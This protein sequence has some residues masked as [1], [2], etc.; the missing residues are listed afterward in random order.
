MKK[1]AIIGGTGLTQMPEL[2]V[3]QNKTVTTQYGS[4][5]SSLLCG[6][7]SGADVVFLARHGS[8]HSIPPHCVNYRAN[9]AALKQEGVSAVIAVNAVGGIR[10]DMS[11][12]TL[13]VPDQIIDYTWGREHTYSDGSDVPLAHVDFTQPY[14]EPLRQQLLSALQAEG[15]AAIN[16]G[17]HGVTQGPRL[18]SAAE[19]DRLE[20][21]GC[22]LVGMTAMPEAALA[23]ELEL[24]YACLALVVNPAA[25]RSVDT[26]SMADIQTVLE[27][28]IP[29]IRAVLARACEHMVE[30]GDSL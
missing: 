20:R 11:A 23:R 13:V 29:K 17:V 25:G 24:G 9:M 5:S 19:I 14:T 16:G 28:S 15:I 10:R 1:I 30:K 4:P 22:D 26:I 18:E 21:D 2:Q 6:Q 12:G 7:L 3:H 27:Q 8:D